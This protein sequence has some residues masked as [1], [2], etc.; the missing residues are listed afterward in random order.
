MNQ[1][2]RLLLSRAG[3]SLLL[4]ATTGAPLAQSAAAGSA[5]GQKNA[6]LQ[7]PAQYQADLRGPLNN[8]GH[9]GWY[10]DRFREWFAKWFGSGT[11]PASGP[12]SVED[13]FHIYYFNH[14]LSR[15]D[16]NS[17]LLVYAKLKKENLWSVVRKVKWAGVGVALLFEPTRSQD[18]LRAHLARSGYGDW[19]LAS[20]G[21]P[22]GVRSRFRGAQ[23][24]FRGGE[25]VNAHI[26]LHNPGDPPS[27]EVTSAVEE[28]PLA[29]E[30]Y[31][32]DLVN[33]KK[34]HTNA[35]VRA[36]LA[37]QGIRVPEVN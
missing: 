33:R 36:A 13:Y 25:F 37:G 27:G 16:R 15:G 23:L 1:T 10:A 8:I 9:Y 5:S 21:N 2:C 12:G 11:R 34:T 28:L 29:V 35:N 22:W 30:H 3:S 31:N 4:L 32:E 26:D 19:W 20:K 24:H 17:L 14:V 18:A 7:L 6:W